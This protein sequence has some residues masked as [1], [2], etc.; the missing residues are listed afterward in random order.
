MNI[1]QPEVVDQAAQA[2]KIPTEQGAINQIQPIAIPTYIIN[3]QF[4]DIARSA[5]GTASGTHTLYTA[6]AGRRY[7]VTGA[8]LSFSKDAT[9]DL[10]SLIMEV[11]R[12]NS[13]RT[14][15]SLKALP[16]TAEAQ[17]ISISFPFPVISD[18]AGTVRVTKTLT[19]GT[20]AWTI[21]VCGFEL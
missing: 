3:K 2:L 18:V 13:Q 21:S 15:L 1:N 8:C 9:S 19:T 10:N 12:D 14:I 7:C 20:N 5:S 6:S 4:S 16:A 11:L 17:S